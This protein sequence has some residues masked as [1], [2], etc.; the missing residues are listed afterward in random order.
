MFL[1][2]LKGRGPEHYIGM[3]CLCT[4]SMYCGVRSKRSRDTRGDRTIS[5]LLTMLIIHFGLLFFS[6]RRSWQYAAADQKLP[7]GRKYITTRYTSSVSCSI[8]VGRHPLGWLGLKS[9]H[10]SHPPLLEWRSIANPFYLGL[11][12]V[13]GSFSEHCYPDYSPP[14]VGG[15]RLLT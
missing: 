15:T 14:A 11:R 8:R 4:K 3:P 1:G 7:D 2:R 10:Q 9:Q 6:R 13:S 12:P 5:A